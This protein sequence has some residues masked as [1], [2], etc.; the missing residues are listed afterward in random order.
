[1]GEN[2][3]SINAGERNVRDDLGAYSGNSVQDNDDLTAAVETS[4]GASGGSTS[5]DADSLPDAAADDDSPEAIQQRIEATRA[6]MSDT[7]N[8]LQA[9]LDPDVIKNQVKE[10]VEEHVQAAKDQVREATIGK[11]EK[12]MHNASETISDAARPVVD[13]VS[14]VAHSALGAAQDA[15][16]QVADK[17]HTV[18]DTVSEKAHTVADTVSEKASH[19][20]EKAHGVADTVSEKASHVANRA[21][22]TGSTVKSSSLSLADTIRENPLP[23][24]LAALGIGWLLVKSQSRTSHQTTATYPGSYGREYGSTKWENQSAIPGGGQ[25]YRNT[26]DD[27]SDSSYEQNGSLKDKASELKDQAADTVSNL[28]DGVTDKASHL[29]DQA[30]DTVSHLKDQASD[31]VSHLSDTAQQKATYL[32]DMARDKAGHISHTAQD[33][34]HQSQ[35][36]LDHTL[37]DSPLVIGAAAMAIGAAIGL[38]IPSTPV[39]SNLMGETRDKVVDNV[40]TVATDTAHKVS[41]VAGRVVEEVSKTAKETATNVAQEV[42]KTAKETATSAAQE[43]GFSGI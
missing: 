8:A 5:F 20:A 23:A 36:W 39:E 7:I 34:V 42:T 35:D 11:A 10:S 40:R 41:T 29:K 26:A 31:K 17:A 37:Q 13:A 6:E 25:E 3:T 2:S 15:G 27:A 1:M 33:K 24:A 19:V 14:R 12:F 4:Y 21:H 9:K 32:A 18:A 16:A 30:T 43:Q 38:A 28:K 22:H